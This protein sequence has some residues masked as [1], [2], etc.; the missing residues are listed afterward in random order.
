MYLAK[1]VWEILSIAVQVCS[2]HPQ[3]WCGLK[4]GHSALV[5]HKH[6]SPPARVVRIET[7]VIASGNHKG[8]AVSIRKD[9]VDNGSTEI[10]SGPSLSREADVG[11]RR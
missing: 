2:L 3:G 6:T 11:Q 9:C 4:H 5:V 10:S 1:P 7:R 8:P